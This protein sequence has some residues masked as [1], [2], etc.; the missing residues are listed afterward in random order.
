[1]NRLHRSP[2]KSIAGVCSGIA[3]TFGIEPILVRL[4]FLASLFFGGSGLLLYI[5]LWIILPVE[6]NHVSLPQ[7]KLYRSRSERFIGG[8]CGGLAKYLNWDV[9]LI[10]LIFIVLILSLGSGLLLYLLLWILIPLEP[11]EL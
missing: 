3:E 4:A 6:E 10:R 2:D 8:V 1:M 7:K 9:S 5:I 11:N